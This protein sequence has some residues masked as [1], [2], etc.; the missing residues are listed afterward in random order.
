MKVVID[1]FN[2]TGEG[3]GRIDGKVIF[4]PKTIPGD[5]VDAINIKDFKNYYRGEIGSILV[6]S[7]DRVKIEC[8]YYHECGG[9]QLMG[10]S[11]LNQ[12]LL[13]Q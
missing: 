10:L 6:G 2:H 8:P 3:I 12:F 9:C 5:I 13:Y 4:I 1:G 7:S 11:Y